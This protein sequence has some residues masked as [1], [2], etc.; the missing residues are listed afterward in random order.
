MEWQSGAR[1]VH[2]SRVTAHGIKDRS[3]RDRDRSGHGWR[4]SDAFTRVA[5]ENKWTRVREDIIRRPNGQDGLYG[6]VERGE[7]AVIVPLGMTAEGPVLTL[8]QQFRYPV[9]RRLW[10]F[11]MGM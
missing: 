5:Y 4:V 3:C 7:F 10:E 2:T 11:P 6:I 8:I 1:I 9:R